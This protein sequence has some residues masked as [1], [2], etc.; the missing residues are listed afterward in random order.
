MLL[1]YSSINANIGKWQLNI[2]KYWFGLKNLFISLA[3]VKD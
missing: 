3:L 2:D 1:N